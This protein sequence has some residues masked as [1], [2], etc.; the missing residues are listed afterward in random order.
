M[1]IASRDRANI[2]YTRLG[3]DRL[4]AGT[5]MRRH[6]NAIAYLAVPLAGGYSADTARRAAA[7]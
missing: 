3:R 5:T 1:S 4:A 6:R 2:A 7:H